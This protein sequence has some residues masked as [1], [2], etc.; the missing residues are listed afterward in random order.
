M[1]DPGILSCPLGYM[2]QIVF[3]PKNAQ[4]AAPHHH[5][6]GLVVQIGTTLQS[7]GCNLMN[8]DPRKTSNKFQYLPASHGYSLLLIGRKR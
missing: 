4:W 1:G 8:L 6:V 7:F 2:L 3:G 5:F